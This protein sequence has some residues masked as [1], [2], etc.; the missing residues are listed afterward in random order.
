MRGAIF[1]LDGTIVD[2][3]PI[4]LE[5]FAIF[6]ER[7]GLPPLTIDDRKRLDGRRNRDIFPDLFRR[8]LS[9]PEHRAFA[10]EKESLYRTLSRGRLSLSPGFER[11]LAR[12]NARGIPAAIAT[13]APPENV[14]HSLVELGLTSRLTCIVRSDQ[15]ARGKPFPD[16]FLAAADRLGVPPADC[17]AFEDAPAGIQA[18]RAAGMQTVAMTTSFGP[19]VFRMPDVAADVI[20]HDFD[21]YLAGAGASLL[22]GI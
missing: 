8:P 15:V 2:N 14:E 12:L 18:A 13:S 5:A 1:D 11:L 16:V 3:M 10:D 6:A 21:E 9:D 22:D 4:H 17:V 20:V 19:D 7:H